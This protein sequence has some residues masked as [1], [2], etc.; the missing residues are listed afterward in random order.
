MFEG[1][2]SAAIVSTIVYAVLGV[3]IGAIVFGIIDMFTPGKLHTYITEKNN[4]SVA[5]V[6]AAV[7]IGISIIVASSVHGV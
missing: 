4:M 6:M 2:S 1:L 5:I 7:I 3:A